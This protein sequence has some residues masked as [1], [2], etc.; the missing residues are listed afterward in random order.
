MGFSN[1]EHDLYEL[2]KT[3]GIT[4]CP[5]CSLEEEKIKNSMKVL[6][7]ESVTK[8]EFRKDIR[9]TG[10]CKKHF[11]MFNESVKE[12]KT[13]AGLGPAII[14]E[15]M[16]ISQFQA[17]DK[18]KR[19]S[20]KSIR[21]DCYF[22]QYTQTLPERL[23][24][25]AYNVL[26]ESKGFNAFSES[27]AIFCLDHYEMI[28]RHAGKMKNKRLQSSLKEVQEVKVMV[29]KKKLRGFIDKHDHF[30]TDKIDPDEAESIDIA[31]RLLLRL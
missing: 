20:N 31:F 4:G 12:D 6:L 22:C 14:F 18:K 5:L 8:R 24:A 23:V 21:K 7:Y 2:I 10:I 13:V 16:L 25:S 19:F 15:D 9:F 11:D 27:R 30:N 26:K 17:M 29:L 28:Q 3:A 1:T